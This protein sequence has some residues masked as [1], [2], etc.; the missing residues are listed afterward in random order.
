MPEA[1]L[2]KTHEDV[3]PPQACPSCGYELDSMIAIGHDDP[4]K[5]GDHTVCIGCAKLLEYDGTKLIDGDA[6][7]LDVQNA[8][9]MA[10]VQQAISQ[11]RKRKETNG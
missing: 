3:H 10:R 2:R 9:R 6:T 8:Q 4:P 11:L 7:K 1:D 5:A